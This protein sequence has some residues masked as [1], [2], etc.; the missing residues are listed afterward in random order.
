MGE[1]ARMP[2]TLPSPVDRGRFQ[3]VAFDGEGCVWEWADDE[4]VWVLVPTSGD[5]GDEP[6]MGPA[7]LN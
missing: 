4:L 6:M 2:T 5:E 1:R 7:T 3:F